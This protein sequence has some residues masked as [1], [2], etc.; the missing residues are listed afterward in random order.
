M[1]LEW[2]QRHIIDFGGDPGNVT[3]AGM[4]AGGG[5]CH[6]SL[7]RQQTH[8]TGLERI[9]D[10]QVASVMYQ[11]SSAQALFKHAIVMSGNYFL[12]PPLPLAQHEDN[13]GRAIA[14]LGLDSASTEER[15]HSLLEAPGQEIISRLAQSVIAAPAVDNDLITDFPTFADLADPTVDVPLG[16]KWCKALM[17]GDAQMDVSAGQY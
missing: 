4:S 13:Y 1:A 14:A 17:I 15:I 11:L 12:I 3:L 8:E 9:V 5:E 7:M 6:F 2:I 16:R 10:M